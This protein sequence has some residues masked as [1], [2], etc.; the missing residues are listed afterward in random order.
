MTKRE[1]HTAEEIRAEVHRLVH[2]GADVIADGVTIGIP[3]PTP[4][5]AGVVDESGA[6]WNMQTFGN[7]RGFEG[8]VLHCLKTVQARW[9]LMS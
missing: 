7:L 2:A 6:N 9:D 8:W 5:A 4:Y 1:G 3:L